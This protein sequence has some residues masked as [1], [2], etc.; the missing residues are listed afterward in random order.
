MMFKK[1]QEEIV[2]FVMIVLLVTIILVVFLGFYLRGHKQD[3]RTESVEVSQFLDSMLEYTT[4]CSLTNGY[5]YASVSSLASDCAERNSLC[6]NGRSACQVLQNSTKEIIESS[7]FFG[8][9]NP[10]KGYRFNVKAG[11]TTL[12]F[13]NVGSV[14]CKSSRSSS[15][16]FQKATFNL[17]ICLS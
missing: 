1:A 10:E 6:S 15:R 9:E 4:E 8:Q 13:H 7:W 14:N 11:N 5:S 2:G 17:E 12:V 3:Y 16:S